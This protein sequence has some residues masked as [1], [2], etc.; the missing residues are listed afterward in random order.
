MMCERGGMSTTWLGWVRAA[1]QPTGRRISWS[2]EHP[3]RVELTI[4]R[5]SF[6]TMLWSSTFACKKKQA[7]P[8]ARWNAALCIE[9]TVHLPDI[10]GIATKKAC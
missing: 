9:F 3:R 7:P 1:I 4:A 6:Q 8:Q 5:R 2:W 10:R